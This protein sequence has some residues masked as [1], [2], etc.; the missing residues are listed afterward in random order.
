ME[1]LPLMIIL[2]LL[3]ACGIAAYEVFDAIERDEYERPSRWS[4]RA[5]VAALSA[6]PSSFPQA[7]SPRSSEEP[8]DVIAERSAV[9]VRSASARLDVRIRSLEG[10]LERLE[11]DCDRIEA[12]GLRAHHVA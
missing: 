7:S 8:G 6:A 3:S 2:G 10:W 9:S 4:G 1:Y 12:F 5:R 11:R